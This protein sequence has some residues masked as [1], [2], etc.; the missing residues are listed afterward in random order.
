M[1]N[2]EL[3]LFVAEISTDSIDDM[4][5]GFY[6]EITKE[7]K[8]KLLKIRGKCAIHIP[9]TS[10]CG[11]KC[12]FDKLC[13]VSKR[14]YLIGSNTFFHESVDKPTI[15]DINPKLFGIDMQMVNQSIDFK[16]E[17]ESDLNYYL[18][19]KDVDMS[20][21]AIFVFKLLNCDISYHENNGGSCSFSYYEIE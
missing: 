8:E 5:K 10:N 20:E 1:T 15:I 7:N 21:Y 14:T 2:N 18:T 9:H 17:N 13:L 19:I 12:G 4:I 11:C 6:P 16:V 3:D